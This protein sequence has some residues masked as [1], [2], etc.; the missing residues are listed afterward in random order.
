MPEMA[1][2]RDNM[3]IKMNESNELE[4]NWKQCAVGV[5]ALL[6]IYGSWY[7]VPTGNRG[8]KTRFG[9]VIGEAKESGFYMK[10]PFI[11]VVNRMSVKIEKHSETYSFY[12]K[13]I[14]RAAITLTVN[15]NLKASKAHDVFRT[16][17]K[18]WRETLLVPAI[19]KVSKDVIGKWDAV[20]LIENRDKAGQM[21][22][23]QLQLVSDQL[24]IDFSGVSMENI[25]YSDVF[26]DAIEAKVV[27]TQKAIESENKTKQIEEEAK[28]KVISAQAEA[29]SM[30]IKAESLSQ[31][32]NLVEYEAV[33]KWNGVLPTVTGG[34]MPF[35]NMKLG[36]K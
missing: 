6:S 34:S 27:A 3:F 20:D 32:K 22:L 16:V 4:I 5:V 19:K 24:N 36:E 18:E 15:Y 11:D 25:D 29:K 21:I 31:N 12:T 14:Q 33:Q 13:D 7:T 30:Q 1:D 8:I 17:G 26:E 2:R 10:L 9:A 35:I 23:E 28:Q